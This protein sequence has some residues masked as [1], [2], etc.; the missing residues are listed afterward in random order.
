QS[1]G[2]W[3]L[4]GNNTFSTGATVQSGLLRVN[5]ELNS[6]LVTVM[7]SS[8]GLGG[9]GVIHG[10]VDNH[11]HFAPG[12]S[13]GTLTVLGSMTN[14]GD[15]DAQV[16]AAGNS[17]Q[18]LVSG[19]ATINGGNVIAEAQ[20]GIYP[21]RSLYRILT[22]TNGVSGM[23]VT[24]SIVAVGPQSALFPITGSSLRYDQNNVYLIVNR[25]PFTS[26]ARTY[27]QN[28][29]A[30]ALNGVNLASASST[31]TNLISQFYWLSSASQAQQALDSLSGEIHG[32]LGLLDVQQQDDFNNSIAR[33]TGRISAN[34]RSGEF[35]TSWKPVQLASAGSELPPMRLQQAEVQQPL[36]FWLQGIGSFGQL[37]SDGNAQGGNYTIS[38]LSGGA[39]YRLTPELLA[40]LGAGYS[41]DNADVGGPGANGTVDAY[42]IGGYGGYVRGPWHLDCILSGGYFQTDTKRFINVGGIQQQAG[43]SYDG[44]VFA[45]STEGGYAFK[46][47]WLTVE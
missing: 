2:N 5:G 24:S 22:A 40:G 9:S 26:M 15:Y 43:G 4:T 30:G 37:D 12:N 7:D 41:H 44:G 39:D 13:I 21:L 16:N 20:S 17:D 6:P 8:G 19:T 35:A 45:L 14:W 25:T 11:G 23:Y 38:G 42:Q 46:F 1:D 33:R 47:D 29:V 27:N 32:T 31:M 36:D 28:S 34:G 10:T 3:N 18:I